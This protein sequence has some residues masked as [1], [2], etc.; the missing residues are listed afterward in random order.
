MTL[1]GQGRERRS[2][3]SLA[4]TLALSEAVTFVDRVDREELRG[5]MDRADVFVHPSRTEGLPRVV[6]EAMARGLPVVA[7]A[8]GGVPEIVEEEF[9]CVPEDSEGLADSIASLLRDP[10]VYARASSGAIEGARPYAAVNCD[11]AFDAWTAL[12]STLAKQ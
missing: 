1:V 5:L 3:E 12:L 4:L 7:T 10:V 11:R 9:L 8:V 2:L 6:L